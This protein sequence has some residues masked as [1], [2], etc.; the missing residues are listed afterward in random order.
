GSDFRWVGWPGGDVPVI[1]RAQVTEMLRERG[2]VPIFLTPKE[3]ARYYNGFCNGVIWPLFHYFTD[4]VHFD[5]RAFASY[6]EV[7]ARFADA[8]AREAPEG[9]R[10]WVHDFQLMLVPRLLRQK[11]PD[12]EIGFFLHIPFPSSEIYRSLP[13]REEILLGVLGSDYIGFQ[14][15]DFARHFRS[16]CLR[17]L[18]LDSDP[19]GVMHQGRRVGVGTHPIGIPVETFRQAL[20]SPAARAYTE[21]L[22]SRY[23][24]RRVLLGVE[25]LDYS[26]GITHKLDAYEEYL[27]RDPERAKGVV[28]LQVI[29]PSRLDNAEYRRLKREIEEQVGRLNG[30]YARPGLTP[31]EYMHRNLDVERLAA[32]YAFVDAM[33]VT[34]VRD[35][36]NLVAQ[37]FVVCQSQAQAEFGGCPGVLLLSEF[38][39]AA[40]SLSRAILVNPWDVHRTA[41]AIEEALAMP[42]SDRTARITGM[43]EH[44]DGM[45]SELWVRDFL[46][47]CSELVARREAGKAKRLD[48]AARDLLAARAARATRRILFLDYDGTLRE[49]TRVPSE[50][51]PTEEIRALLAELARLPSTTV[52]V[53]SGRDRAQMEAWLGD[54]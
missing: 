13:V 12:L 40:H 32:L 54:L 27:R 53:V 1:D 15:S 26:K 45:D 34:P 21:E 4:R 43:A 17:V 30:R 49:I 52:H 31:V 47:A 37:E 46:D 20:R 51:R 18:G 28:L 9:A 2:L 24:K 22:R 7:N 11:R 35:G 36:M 39:G 23:K 16:S 6:E 41:D 25:R 19:D 10:V 8:L 42:D 14:T 3:R 29:V 48:S 38:A 44:V 33:L 50:A 5:R